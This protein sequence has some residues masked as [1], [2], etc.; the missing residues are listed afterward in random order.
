[1][2]SAARLTHRASVERFEITDVPLKSQR[3]EML[4]GRVRVKNDLAIER[5]GALSRQP[6]WSAQRETEL[7]ARSRGNDSRK[8]LALHAPPR[9]TYLADADES[10]GPCGP[11]RCPE[12]HWHADARRQFPKHRTAGSTTSPPKVETGNEACPRKIAVPI[13][14]VDPRARQ[15]QRETDESLT[16]GPPRIPAAPN[17][18]TG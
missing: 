9:R 7:A 18:G 4:T 1:M 3:H 10:N 15:P 17:V 6:D 16:V 13:R 2:R 11:V 12:I 5:Q 8:P 14:T